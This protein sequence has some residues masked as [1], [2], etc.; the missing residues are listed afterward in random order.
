MAIPRSSTGKSSLTVRY[1]ELAAAEATKNT[2]H[3]RAVCVAAVRRPCA[4]RRPVTASKIPAL[5]YES[6]D[7][8][9]PPDRVE[10]P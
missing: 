1:A 9:S 4:K 10:E 3:Q 5:A 7:H 8:R 2:P 6:G